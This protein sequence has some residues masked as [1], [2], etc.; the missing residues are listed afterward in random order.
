MLT[1]LRVRI[2]MGRE[3]QRRR[4][5]LVGGIISTSRSAITTFSPLAV[6]REREIVGLR[7]ECY[8]LS[9]SVIVVALLIYSPHV[10]YS[11]RMYN[12]ARALQQT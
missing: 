9:S 2:H 5:G 4:V 11:T 8:Y 10:Y 12:H 6:G 1:E 7:C 3:H